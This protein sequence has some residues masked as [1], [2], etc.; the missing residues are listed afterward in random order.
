MKAKIIPL[1]MLTR[2]DLPVDR[3][4]DAAKEK[5][6]GVV[7]LGYDKNG[8]TYFASS[9]ADGGT[10]LWLLEKCKKQLLD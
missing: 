9:Y 4:L 6:E 8:E 1:N 3:I 10:I 5:L 7:L 2:I